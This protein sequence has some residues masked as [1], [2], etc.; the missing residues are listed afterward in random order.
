MTALSNGY[1][2]PCVV[3]DIG[4][5]CTKMGFSGEDFPRAYFRS[6]TA[7][8][9]NSKQQN[10]GD[11]KNRIIKR[12]HD[13]LNSSLSYD[14]CSDKNWEIANPVDSATGLIYPTFSDL[15]RSKFEP[16]S[17]QP[18]SI[19]SNDA[20]CIDN[21]FY[22][23]PTTLYT[24]ENGDDKIE[25]SYSLFDSYLTHG[26]NS[27]LRINPSSSPILL[28]ER[29]YNPP[30]IRQKCIE[31]LF[32]SQ[33]VP[34]V[35]FSR[36]AV[37][38]C[39][40]VGRTTATV[41]DMGYLGTVIS[42]V[43]DGFVEHK[44]I[45]KSPI[46]GK[47]ID[48]R[49]LE[50]LDN[51]VKVNHSGSLSRSDLKNANNPAVQLNSSFDRNISFK[52][53]I[54]LGNVG[55]EIEK[56][57]HATSFNQ[58]KFRDKISYNDN[59]HNLY[60]LD[61]ARKCKE[62]GSGAGVAVFG[63]SS[64]DQEDHCKYNNEKRKRN[65]VYSI[66]ANSSRSP[67]KLPDGTIVEIP[68]T[69]CVDAAEL[70]FGM[71]LSSKKRREQ[72][73][74]LLCE[75][76]QDIISVVES[77]N[78]DNVKSITTNVSNSK[79]N[80]IPKNKKALSNLGQ[81]YDYSKNNC[82]IRTNPENLSKLMNTSSSEALV[83]SC[84]PFLSSYLNNITT[85][86]VQSSIYEAVLKC[87]KDQQRELLEN[88][89]LCGGGACLATPPLRCAEIFTSHPEFS[90]ENTI[91]KRICYETEALI[92]NNLPGLKVKVFSPRITERA[93]CSWLGGSILGS[94]G[95]FNEMWITRNDYNE[96]GPSIV[97]RKCP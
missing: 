55:R 49:V 3:A 91:L 57:F 42:P 27:A 32:E 46:G 25:N 38:A 6:T 35:F 8:L 26:Y 78:T 87:N 19:S 44:G 83:R 12:S 20:Y 47:M 84:I 7:A 71:D 75:E 48:S 22:T 39:Y 56:R 23:P 96:Y 37:C 73:V 77:F 64:L 11:L 66:Y 69:T 18:E 52:H 89:V 51:L 45:L 58:T 54:H 34:A 31:L 60:R 1:E 86:T 63:Y 14:K 95:S 53:V 72:A 24:N 30:P 67:Y 5:Y 93:I 92:R 85:G 65:R 62:D 80:F 82:Y 61:V 13:D 40:A 16:P 10:R 79:E 94:L 90:S 33:N 2:F 97:N 81:K 15:K 9:R 28:I 74:S 29:S 50:I 88:V 21:G 36:D 76:T 68:L 59:F 43:F 4:S 70:F 41:V 17:I